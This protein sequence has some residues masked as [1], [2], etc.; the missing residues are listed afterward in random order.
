M[1]V[2]DYYSDSETISHISF[3]ESDLEELADLDRSFDTSD[4]EIDQADDLVERINIWL[5]MTDNNTRDPTLEE[6]Y[7]DLVTDIM[8]YT[9]QFHIEN[10]NLVSFDML[11]DLDLEELDTYRENLLIRSESIPRTLYNMVNQHLIH[12]NNKINQIIDAEFT[13]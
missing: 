6:I 7:M 11:N 12:V 3:T 5:N 13:N 2:S 4:E 10:L 8:N 9:I 1:S